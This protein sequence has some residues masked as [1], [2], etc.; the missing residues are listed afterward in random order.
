[1]SL[2]EYQIYSVLSTNE[3]KNNDDMD[4]ILSIIEKFNE[5]QSL[6]NAKQYLEKELNVKNGYANIAGCVINLNDN[7]DLFTV[8]IS[9]KNENYKFYYNK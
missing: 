2:N 4:K 9:F 8:N 6:T 7:P 3:S 5:L 1:M